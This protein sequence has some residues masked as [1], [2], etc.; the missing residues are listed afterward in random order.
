[1]PKRPATILVLLA[2]LPF[3]A[4]SRAQVDAPPRPTASLA[5]LLR[6]EPTGL[7]LPASFARGKIPLLFIADQHRGAGVGCAYDHGPS[8]ARAAARREG[9]LDHRGAARVCVFR[10]RPRTAE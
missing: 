6:Y 4:S 10:G 3:A 8:R 7:S 1:M 2:L 5:H 9:P